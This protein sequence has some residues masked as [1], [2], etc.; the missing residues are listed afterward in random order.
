MEG[1]SLMTDKFESLRPEKQ[2]VIVN[3]AYQVFSKNGYK[4]ASTNEIVKIAGISKGL[5]FHYFK[6]KENLYLYLYKTGITIVKERVYDSIDLNN[7]DYLDRL[8]LIGLTKLALSQIYPEIFDFITSA[9]FEKEEEVAIKIH[10]LNQEFLVE[11]YQ[12]LRENIDF[13]LFRED[14]DLEMI[15]SAIT[16]VL[17][18]FAEKLAYRQV[19]EN[20]QKYDA[21]VISPMMDQQIEFLK[22]S[23]YKSKTK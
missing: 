20:I 12:K 1:E 3:A 17:Q 22:L 13:S 16:A 18:D 23:F 14:L 9:Y 21:E 10:S 2:R 8:K 19:Q 6:T 11:G 15:L 7:S 5:L 4:R